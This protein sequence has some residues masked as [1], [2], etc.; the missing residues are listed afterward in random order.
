M[1]NPDSD[2]FFEL[3]QFQNFSSGYLYLTLVNPGNL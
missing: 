2:R 1:I 3:G